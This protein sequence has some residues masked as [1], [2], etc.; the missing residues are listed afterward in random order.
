[1][2]Q[3]CAVSILLLSLISC[4]IYLIYWIYTVTDDLN[5]IDGDT[6]SPLAVVSLGVITCGIY[7][8]YWWYKLGERIAKIEKNPNSN[9]SLVFLMLSLFGFSIVAAMIA[10]NKLNKIGLEQKL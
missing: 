9:D 2:R 5:S 7:T 8:L 10:Q 4:G 6:T 3:R 1:M